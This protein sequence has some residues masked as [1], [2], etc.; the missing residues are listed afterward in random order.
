MVDYSLAKIYKIVCDEEPELIYFGSTCERLS[1]RMGAHRSAYRRYLNGDGKFVSSFKI[2][3]HESANIVLVE[4]FPCESKDA[5]H[6]RERFWIES[7]AC[8]NKN[9]PGS[10]GVGTREYHKKYYARNTEKIKNYQAEYRKKRA[11]KE[12]NVGGEEKKNL[13]EKA[14]KAKERSQAYACGKMVCGCGV[15][16]IRSG[17]TNH[18][19]SAKHKKN[20]ELRKDNVVAENI[21]V[22]NEEKMDAIAVEHVEPLTV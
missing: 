7:T 8:V 12:K 1:N 6:A 20:M 5:L 10:Y 11:E 14:K 4:K 13:E 17:K 18:L 21:I 15:T 9:I 2:L 16:H 3:K 19:R 22:P